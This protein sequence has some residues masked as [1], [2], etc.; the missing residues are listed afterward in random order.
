MS[1]DFG[2]RGNYTALFR[3]LDNHGARECGSGLAY[4][5]YEQTELSVSAWLKKLK[6]ELLETIRP[7]QDDRIY[8]I[9]R[10]D[11]NTN[12]AVTVRGQFILGGRKAAPWTGYGDKPE[13]ALAVESI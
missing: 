3:F 13:G 9:W 8:L 7:T 12:K 11:D 5:E 1:Y 10:D 4:F 6:S 2:L